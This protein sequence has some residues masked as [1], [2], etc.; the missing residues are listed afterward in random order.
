MKDGIKLPFR[1]G[2]SPT[3]KIRGVL[4][5]KKIRQGQVIER[6][7]AIIYPKNQSVIEL[8]IFDQYVFDW[9][10]QHEALALGYGSLLNHSYERNVEVDFD[11]NKGE[12]IFKALREIKAGEELLINYNDDSLEPVDQGYLSYDRDLK[13]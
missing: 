12:V 1:V 7:P 8:T 4:A 5:T 10:E 13:I 3:L 9:D 6:C 11:K 2:I